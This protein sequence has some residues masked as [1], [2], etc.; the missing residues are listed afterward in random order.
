MNLIST[1]K[2]VHRKQVPRTILV[3]R[4]NMMWETDF[5]KV[6]IEGEGRM[7]LTAYLDL[8][9]R[10]IKGHL[11]SR[12]SRKAE[13]IEAVNNALLGSFQ[14]LNVNDLR[15]RTDNGSQLT[16]SGNEKPLKKPGIMHE[17]IYAHTPVSKMTLNLT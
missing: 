7:H 8:C 6:Y 9:S 12:M 11:V 17:T 4:P 14:D 10:K 15:I 2:K 13:M 16:S 5:T 3:A 1:R